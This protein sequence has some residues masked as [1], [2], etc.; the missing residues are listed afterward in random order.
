L[1]ASLLFSLT[2]IASAQAA[3]IRIMPAGDSITLGTADLTNGGYRGPLYAQ[4]TSAGHSV[5]FV[6]TQKSGSIPDNNHE[7]HSG[8]RA[9]QVASSLY[10]WLMTNPADIVLLH[11]GTN[12][13]SQGQ[14]APGIVDD[15]NFALD[16]IEA[17]ES[18]SHQVVTVVL[19]RI[20]NRSSPLGAQGLET[21]RLNVS[22]ASLAAARIAAGDHL[23]LVDQEPA[24]NYPAD[25]AD[26]VHPN[27]GGYAKMATVWYNTLHPLLCKKAEFVSEAI[28]SRMMP[29]QSYGCSVSMKNVGCD[30]WTCDPAGS[31]L[32]V[33]QLYGPAANKLIPAPYMTLPTDPCTIDVAANCTFPFSVSVP[34]NTP[35]GVYT[36]TCQM[37]DASGWHQG[38]YVKDVT[39]THGDDALLIADT[40]PTNMLPLQSQ[41]VSV[42]MQNTGLVTWTSDVYSLGSLGN[43][44]P[45]A[46]A[47]QPLDP[48]ETI[49]PGESKTFTFT[50]TAPATSGNYGTDWQMVHDSAFRWFGSLLIKTVKVAPPPPAITQ[51]PAAQ[52]VC[53]GAP[54]VFTAVASGQELAYR[55]QFGG[56]DLSDNARQSGTGTPTLT[57]T[58]AD[59]SLT[60]NYRCKVSNFGG[61]AYTNTAALSLKPATTITEQPQP[62]TVVGGSVVHFAAAGTGDGALAYQW[63][64]DGVSLSEGGHYS[65]TATATLTVSSANRRDTGVYRC[66]ITAGCGSALSDPAAL[67]LTNVA[68]D[69]DLDNDVDQSDFGLFQACLTGDGNPPEG[70]DCQDARLDGDNDVDNAD[71]STFLTCFNG[72]DRTPMCP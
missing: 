27:S 67:L 31:A 59:A 60:G 24:L 41:V 49:A 62:R 52:V 5:N 42:T 61:A 70:L 58:S 66:Q 21:S 63:Q 39:V 34:S 64:K 9:D 20:I 37:R 25:M 56:V 10:N 43:S 65:G 45:F 33:R 44:D 11:I 30:A 32:T 69:L 46:A 47:R 14:L 19:A 51:H 6:G 22:I 57:L 35:W 4:L 7:G 17:Y 13:I 53:P 2:A 48:G 68:A 1:A 38:V 36:L 18:A 71:V 40:I 3:D 28:P 55:W 12:D 72:P 26:A 8:W 15:I 16:E 23:V 50:M 29:G 54:A